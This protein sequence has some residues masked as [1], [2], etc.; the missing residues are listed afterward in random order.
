MATPKKSSKKSAG[1]KGGAA[2]KTG[3][4]F[5]VGRVGSLLRKG[6]YSRRVS[7]GAAVFL[8][9][10]LEYLTAETLELASKTVAKGS[11]RITPRAILLAVRNDADLGSLL[12]NVTISR[13]GVSS[14]GV[15]KGLEKKK[16]GASKKA[17]KSSKSTPKA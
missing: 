2:K 15:A 1:A 13:G 5:P 7:S 3:L 16:K 12:Q 8:A 17:A 6:R 10:T 14:S 4:V 9:A 11:K